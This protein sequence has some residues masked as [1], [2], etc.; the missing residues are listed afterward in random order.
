MLGTDRALRCVR[1]LCACARCRLAAALDI[2]Y[3]LTKPFTRPDFYDEMKGLS[4]AS[5]TDFDVSV[6]APTAHFDGQTADQRR[7]QTIRRIHMIG[8]GLSGA[9]TRRT[10]ARAQVS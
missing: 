1:P 2:E 10:P 3:D 9:R 8:S 5:G 7:S 6:C 4:Q